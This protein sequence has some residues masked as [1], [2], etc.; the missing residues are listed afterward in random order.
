MDVVDRG[1]FF[2]EIPTESLVGSVVVLDI[3]GT[4]TCSSQMCVRDSVRAKVA[5][6]CE[7]NTVY[8]FSNNFNG[9]R[10]RQIARDLGI[11]YIE[12]P[13]KK[14]STKILRYI[15]HG[16]SPI[17]TIGDKFL[18]DELFARFAKVSYLRVR[19]Y[20]CANDSLWD[21][22]ACGIDDLSYVIARILRLTK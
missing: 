1:K 2:H 13:H 22:L 8:I 16:V 7:K 21:R 19:R 18:T 10:S 14:P 12:A 15:D 17:V 20:R 4:I 3:D 5:Q 9:V 11:A 6:I